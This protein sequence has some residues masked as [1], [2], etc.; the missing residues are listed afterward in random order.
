MTII[1]NRINIGALGNRDISVRE[2]CTPGDIVI[3]IDG[4]DAIIGNQVFNTINRI[5]HNNP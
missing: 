5:Y 2:R 1:R 3:D 4:D